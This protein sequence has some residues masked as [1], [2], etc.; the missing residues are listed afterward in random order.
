MNAC[1]ASPQK[2]LLIGKWTN[3]L[4][5]DM[6]KFPHQIVRRIQPRTIDYKASHIESFVHGHFL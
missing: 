5:F 3:P 4:K 2:G 1:N 6:N